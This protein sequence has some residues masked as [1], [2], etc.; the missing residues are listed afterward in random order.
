MVITG[1]AKHWSWLI[2]ESHSTHPSWL[3]KRKS[4]TFLYAWL[5]K[6]EINTHSIS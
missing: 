4:T 2:I 5:I 6:Q 1:S 3:V